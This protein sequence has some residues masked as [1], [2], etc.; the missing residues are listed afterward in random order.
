MDKELLKIENLTIGFPTKSG[1]HTVVDHVNLEVGKGEIVG[2]V[3]ESGSGKSM[4]SLA[5]MGLLSEEAQVS[6]GSIQLNGQE[7]LGMS[8][9][10]RRKIQGKNMS[11]VFQEPMTSLNPVMKIGTQVGESLKLHTDLDKEAIR[12]RVIEA[13]ASVGLR[14]PELLVDQYPHEISGG[15]R[16]RVMIA[17]AIINHPDLIIAD[18]PTT[19]LDVTVQAQILNLLKKIHRDMGSSI[20]FISH[21]LNVIKEVCQKVV[22][23]Y[24]GV[25]VERGDA[26]EVLKHPKH[27]YTRKLVAS[28]PDQ[29]R[30]SQ[31]TKK[32]LEVQDLNVY[33]KENK[34]LFSSKDKRKHIIHDMSFDLYEGEILGV[35]GESGCGKS[36]LAK[37]IVGLNREYDGK[38]EMDHL[39]PQMVFQDPF[40][41][42]N[43]ARKIG[44][45]LE[46]PLKLKG[47]KDKKQRK[48]LVNQML[49]EIGLDP[50]FANRYAR[51]LSGGQRQRISIGLSLMR[52]EKLIIAD[53]PVSALD[54]TVQSQILRLLLKLHD[55]K[56]LT[57][58]FISHD[59]NVVHHMCHRVIVM[60]LGRI[61]EMADV[62]ELYDHPC[63]PYTRMLFDSILTD[64]E[65][66]TTDSVT[67]NEILPETV[68]GD[69]GCTFY[70]RCRYAGENCLRE[71][72]TLTD[73]GTP[74]HPHLVRCERIAYGEKYTAAD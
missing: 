10:E 52:G 4:T 35:V 24:K 28:M 20:L 48:E 53:E 60:Y 58:M 32:L 22:V 49:T 41:S 23:M 69:G 59:L 8:R 37:T 54:V 40:S 25:I 26:K 67:V 29:V 12:G 62:D 3:G 9:E 6:E 31:N 27:E 16:Q 38:L 70:G 18:E 65:K 2:I 72:P 50:S 19:A 63:H 45:I 30:K 5:V 66:E 51:E 46:E 14:N 42:L 34:K 57:Y 74:G 36:T 33:Y 15:M 43:P 7:L 21:D 39:K 13:L 17:M 68:D 71:V 1:I 44:W 47:I 64:E 56:N 11:M 55:E 61:V 73:I